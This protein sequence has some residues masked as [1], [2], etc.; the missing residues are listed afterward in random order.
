MAIYALIDD[1][2]DEVENVIE[3][4]LESSWPIPAGKRVEPFDSAK[5]LWPARE[6]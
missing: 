5:H 6:G 2:T 1:Q 3:Y 4:D